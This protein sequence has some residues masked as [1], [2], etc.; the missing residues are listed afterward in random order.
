M[1]VYC[2]DLSTHRNPL[3]SVFLRLNYSDNSYY[4]CI[5]VVYA[6]KNSKGKLLQDDLTSSWRHCNTGI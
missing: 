6:I 2:K 3:T 5:I 1:N 4:K